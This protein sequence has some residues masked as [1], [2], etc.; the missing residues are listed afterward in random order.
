MTEVFDN[1]TE[2][3]ITESFMIRNNASDIFEVGNY[4]VFVNTQGNT[5]IREIYIVE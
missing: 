3:E 4:R 1:G 2:N 5:Q